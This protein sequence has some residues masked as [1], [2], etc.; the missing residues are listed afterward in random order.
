MQSP[1]PSAPVLLL[2]NPRAGAGRAAR[3]LPRLRAFARQQHW[4][5]EILVT[6]SAKDLAEKARQAA[7]S[8]YRRLVVLGGDGTF[9]VVLNAIAGH[10][11]IALGLL[12]A[13]GGNDLAASLGLPADPLAAAALL[14]EGEITCI[15]AIRVR[16]ADGHEQVYAGGGG[17]GL[18]AE[19]AR[20]A[21]GT[22][23][24]VPGRLRYLLSAVRALR[25]FEPLGVTV[26]LPENGPQTVHARLLLAAVLNTPTYGAGLCLAPDARLDDGLLD[27]VFLDDLSAVEVLALLPALSMT[28]KLQTPKLRRFRT[29]SLRI[30]TDRPCAFHGDGEILGWAPV[31][32]SVVPGAIRIL[33]PVPVVRKEYP[34][35]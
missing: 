25:A 12:P 17:V 24:N 23:R 21:G 27:V 32:V 35:V 22:F 29:R 33:R 31:E 6:E 19:A 8:G 7:N 11:E 9:H 18:D 34:P 26:T 16:T 14:R 13:G 30:E 4:P 15:D 20:H 1:H 10:R 5:I 3:L 28:G 2:A